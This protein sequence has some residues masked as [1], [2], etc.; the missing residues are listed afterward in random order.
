MEL[1]QYNE[2]LFSTVGTDG[3]VHLCICSCLWVNTESDVNFSRISSAILENNMVNRP[4]RYYEIYYM[5][6]I[7][8]Y[9]SEMFSF[10]MP[11]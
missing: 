9:S 4:V 7:L 2:Y 5:Y 11:L 8:Y 10:H 1:V 3:L 6:S